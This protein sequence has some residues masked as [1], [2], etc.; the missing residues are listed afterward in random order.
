MRAR[1]REP[2]ERER[3]ALAQELD[4]FAPG[5]VERVAVV[6]CASL[7]RLATLCGEVGDEGRVQL[8]AL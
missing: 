6:R 8:A 5:H 3:D 7:A 4:L 1:E 2:R